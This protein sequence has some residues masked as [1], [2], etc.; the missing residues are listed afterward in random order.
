MAVRR[1][2]A[3]APVRYGQAPKRSHFKVRSMSDGRA[4]YCNV[5]VADRLTSISVA[6]T[7]LEGEIL[8]SLN[9]NPSSFS[10]TALQ[11]EAALWDRYR[12]KRITFSFCPNVGTSTN[13]SLVG[14]FDVDVVDEGGYQVGTQISLTK[15]CAQETASQ[16]SVYRPMSWSYRGAPDLPYLYI[17]PGTDAGEV[18][19]W[20]SCGVFA[21]LA[22]STYADTYNLGVLWFDAEYEFT[23]R[24][25]EAAI[26]QFGAFTGTITANTTTTTPLL[27]GVFARKTGTSN[28][29]FMLLPTVVSDRSIN[30]GS[31]DYDKTYIV[32]L[33]Q[34]GLTTCTA[35]GSVTVS[36]STFGSIVDSSASFSS[37]A[38][39]LTV[40]A[41]PSATGVLRLQFT[42][43]TFATGSTSVTVFAA[44]IP[45]LVTVMT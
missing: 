44:S 26:Q 34:G 32:R 6:T 36:S 27:N 39:Q 1:A 19:R 3:S 4:D 8:Y 17:N 29:N 25:I 22:N 12:L 37:T 23:N 38:W 30:F 13:G 33:Y 40:Q 41:R 28:S 11:V 14:G 15:F 24:N 9:L 5:H 18:A 16:D 31:L 2:M 7:T 45:T 21:L 10:N 20:T 43:A 35:A 42:G